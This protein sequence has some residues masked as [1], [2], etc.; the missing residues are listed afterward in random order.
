V[1]ASTG[2][3]QPNPPTPKGKDKKDRERNDGGRQSGNGCAGL[4]TPATCGPPPPVDTQP[5][6]PPQTPQT[7]NLD[8]SQVCTMLTQH[9][10]TLVKI[11]EDE[12][13]GVLWS[14][15]DYAPGGAGDGVG[16]VAATQD[17]AT[18]VILVIQNGSWDQAIG[19]TCQNGI[20]T[21]L[22]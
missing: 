12:V 3:P 19:G 17:G 22:D 11:G 5:Q 8:P 9:D 1:L 21:P 7:G 6:V 20:F 16:D 4:L 15:Y 18:M 13:E 10:P 14:E 2:G